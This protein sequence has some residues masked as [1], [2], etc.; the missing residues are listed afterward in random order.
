M[1]LTK[2][3]INKFMSLEDTGLDI[4]QNGLF[5][6]R[7][8][9]NG[10]DTASNGAGK[11]AM[12]EAIFWAL[13]G[14]T[15]RGANTGKDWDV[16]LHGVSRDKP[17]TIRRTKSNLDF[18][19]Q[20]VNTEAYLKTDKQA[21]ID[22]YVLEHTK[23]NTFSL[24]TYFTPFTITNWF[25]KMSDTDRKNI[26]LDVLDLRWLDVV[27]NLIKN[28]INEVT[29][30]IQSKQMEIS[31]I[32]GY[33]AGLKRSL[34]SNLDIHLEQLQ[35]ALKKY[36]EVSGT[37]LGIDLNKLYDLTYVKKMFSIIKAQYNEMNTILLNINAE[38][39]KIFSKKSELNT[40]LAELARRKSFIN[41][42][43]VCPTCRRPLDDE[44]KQETLA[45]INLDEQKLRQELI[46]IE[47][48][49]K[50]I[51]GLQQTANV[52]Y[53]T[54]REI[55]NKLQ[56]IIQFLQTQNKNTT[57]ISSLEQKKQQ[58]L[59][60]VSQLEK[61]LEEL[62]LWK[63]IFSSTGIKADLI[64]VIFSQIIERT[65]IYSQM[66]GIDFKQK[67]TKGRIKY[68]NYK[69]LSSGERRRAEI[70]LLFALR[71]AIPVPTNLLVIDEVFDH[72]DALGLQ[73]VIPLLELISEKQQVFVISHRPDLILPKV[74][75]DIIVEKQNQKS[76]IRCSV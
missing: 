55:Q 39:T 41:N 48:Q 26:L 53:E 9:V 38:I 23:W 70:A 45:E 42:S 11:S 13:Y 29:A 18:A 8:I 75:L 49:Y 59:K 28:D 24:L 14:K 15:L 40:K 71:D 61:Q 47:Q 43:S 63:N 1:L 31:R 12:V 20:G 21:L 57:D 6:V 33:I 74:D 36:H 5:S 7:G 76:K 30:Q 25:I 56:V 19:M 73:T 34:A 3:E 27:Y 16:I 60:E 52:L 37:D 2:L 64:Q 65:S 44:Y 46:G 69:A 32:D 54:L 68:E 72:L 67:I 10:Q 58:Y 35:E 4:P 62:K 66:L 51:S 22:R 17:F 50:E